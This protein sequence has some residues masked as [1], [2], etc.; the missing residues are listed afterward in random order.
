[1]DA[2]FNTG[3]LTR[4]AGIADRVANAAHGDEALGALVQAAKDMYHAQTVAIILLSEGTGHLHVRASRGLGAHYAAQFK[5]PL[6][7]GVLA[8]VILGGMP[9]VLADASAASQER[10]E[11]RLEHDFGSA[12]IA[13]ITINHKPVG[14]L[15]C[16]HR[17][18]GRFGREDLVSFR[19]L[20]FIAALAIE[21]ADLQEKVSRLAVEDPVTGLFTYAHFY[22]R[23]SYEVARALRYEENL[24]VLL[25]AVRDIPKIVESRGDSAAH[26][27]LRAI[28]S[29]LKENIRAVDFA[30]RFGRHEII[31]CL[32]HADEE[33]LSAVSERLAATAGKCRVSTRAAKE[34]SRPAALEPPETQEVDVSLYLA[35]AVAPEHGRDAGTLVANVQGALLAAK[36]RGAGQMVLHEK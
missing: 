7:S 12:M 15:Y 29:L 28:A 10:D 35:G 31:V 26:D 3:P 2:D 30:A 21:K 22:N 20:S 8:E 27:V 14:C 11:L 5:R 36:S 16:D 18:E 4:L 32:V 19:A 1:M 9:L 33:G 17:Q 23:L 34:A 13:P 25:V 24:G 6:G